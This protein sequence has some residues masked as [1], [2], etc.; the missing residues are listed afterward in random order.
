[1][2]QIGFY[3]TGIIGLSGNMARGSLLQIRDGNNR[4]VQV[5]VSGGEVLHQLGNNN[6]AALEVENANVLYKQIGN[7]LA[8]SDPVPVSNYGGTGGHISMTQ[9]L[10][11]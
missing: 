7:D 2:M 8:A 3:N 4:N 11:W 1:M 6:T 9:Y 10:D 5:S